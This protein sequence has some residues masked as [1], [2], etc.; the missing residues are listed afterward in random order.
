MFW[1]IR[2][3]SYP[4]YLLEIDS[5]VM[6]IALSPEK[7]STFLAVGLQNG[8]ILLYEKYDGLS[9]RFLSGRFYE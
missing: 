5:G 9:L 4:E 7:S 2:N 1:S 3:P 6:A 8:C